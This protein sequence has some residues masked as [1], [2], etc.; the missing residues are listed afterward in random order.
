MRNDAHPMSNP[1]GY[2][3]P[4]SPPESW[5][6]AKVGDTTPGQTAPTGGSPP[7]PR[8]K[9]IAL[10]AFT[11]VLVL[12]VEAAVAGAAWTR[13][14]SRSG[15]AAAS[16]SSQGRVATIPQITSPGSATGR[17]SQALDTQAVAAMV[18][19]AVVDI[20]TT[21]ASLG[22]PGQAAGTGII[23]TSTGEILTN[24]HVIQGATDVQ[25]T[26]PGRSA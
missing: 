10:A 11:S 9:W 23:L 18:E 24:N 6:S 26:I 2:V 19:P 14:H 16:Q 1:S 12:S 3:P 5:A 17:G 8:L 20:N 22:Q 4:Q 21:I 13:T 25:L 7:R 15:P